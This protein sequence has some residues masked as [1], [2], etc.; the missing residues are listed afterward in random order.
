MKPWLAALALFIATVTGAET[1]EELVERAFDALEVRVHDHWAFTRTERSTAGVYVARHDPRKEQPWDLLT[2]DGREPS[3]DERE[4]FLAERAVAQSADDDDEASRT[5]VSPG[6]VEL[7]AETAERWQFAFRP[8]G[9]GEEDAKFMGA[10]EGRLEVARDDHYIREIHLRNVKTI[11]PGKGVRLEVF[12]TRLEFAPSP[13][14]S[15]VLPAVV[16]AK[17]KGRA[18]FVIGIDE[19]QTIEFSDYERV[20]DK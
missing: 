12:E 9:D 2:V 15:A 11:K 17:V 6:S 8:Q 5:I 13:D 3:G 7:V 10:V 14:G 18:M 19:E 16:H 20:I 4:A 1:H